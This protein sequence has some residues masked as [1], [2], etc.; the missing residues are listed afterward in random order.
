MRAKDS[1]SRGDS[2]NAAYAGKNQSRPNAYKKNLHL[3]S[4]VG[5]RGKSPGKKT[6]KKSALSGNGDE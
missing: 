6:T 3:Y 1:P 5:R 2:P 4:K